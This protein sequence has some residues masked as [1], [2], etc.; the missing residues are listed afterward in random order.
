MPSRFSLGF[1]LGFGFL[2]AF[3]HSFYN[4]YFVQNS[5]KLFALSNT[6]FS[7]PRPICNYWKNCAK[8]LAYMLTMLSSCGSVASTSF[9]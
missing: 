6:L 2:F 9:T 5:F 8:F 4:Q 1:G 3:L 7:S